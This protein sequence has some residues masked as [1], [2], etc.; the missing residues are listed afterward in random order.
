M[1]LVKWLH[2]T[3]IDEYATSPGP[4]RLQAIVRT[5]YTKRGSPSFDILK[6]FAGQGET[7]RSDFEQLFKLLG[8]LGKHV[9]V[10]KKLVEAAV[11]L[12]QDFAQG[13]VFQI[14]PSSREQK[15][16]LLPKEATVEGTVRRMF[17][18]TEEQGK[19]MARL[20][21]IWNESDLSE[22]LKKQHKTMTRVHAELLLIDHFDRHGCQFLDGNDKYIGCSKPACY[23]C[24][25]YITNHPGRYGT[26]PSHQ[27]LY[28]GWRT[29]DVI[30]GNA[31]DEKR[32]QFQFR[33]MLKL[34]ETV[35]RDLASDIENRTARLPYHADS[36]AGM[37]SASR[38]RA[39]PFSMALSPEDLS[40]DGEFDR[41]P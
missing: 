24:Y 8:K 10:A 12:P 27:K 34:I 31:Q 41:L 5:C 17:S 36:T 21:F 23:L 7:R 14:V 3:F 28:V 15:L 18:S 30:P 29:P 37:S 13:F 2:E 35:R 9:H 33:M 40:F 38:T 32:Q 11:L 1:H 39:S 20:R 19:F 26:P 4:D 22:L 25:A 16:P 6:R